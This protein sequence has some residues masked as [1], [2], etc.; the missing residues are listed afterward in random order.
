MDEFTTIKLRKYKKGYEAEFRREYGYG[1][2]PKEAFNSLLRTLRG[3][4]GIL[5]CA[6]FDLEDGTFFIEQE[7]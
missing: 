5:Q 7:E 3:K 6:V 4:I 1:G 2:T